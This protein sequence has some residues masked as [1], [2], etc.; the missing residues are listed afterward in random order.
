M[1]NYSKLINNLPLTKQKMV[2]FLRIFSPCMLEA[3]GTKPCPYTTPIM[4]HHFG[5]LDSSTFQGQVSF[6][7]ENT[8]WFHFRLLT[9]SHLDQILVFWTFEALIGPIPRTMIPFWNPQEIPD[10]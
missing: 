3:R 4:M 1:T 2:P 10:G 7:T 6:F 5:K 9:D 8:F